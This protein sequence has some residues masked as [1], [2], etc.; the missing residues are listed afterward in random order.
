MYKM[1]N[2]YFVCVGNFVNFVILGFLYFYIHR[3][4]SNRNKPPAIKEG[5]RYSRLRNQMIF[6]IGHTASVFPQTSVASG[7]LAALVEY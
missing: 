3:R 7:V 4:D 5:R 2:S 6:A 1:Q